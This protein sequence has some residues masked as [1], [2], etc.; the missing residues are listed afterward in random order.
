MLS[1]VVEGFLKFEEFEEFEEFCVPC[2]ALWEHKFS[3]DG[4]TILR[5]NIIN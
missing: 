4:K 1:G 3:N 2:S 5:T